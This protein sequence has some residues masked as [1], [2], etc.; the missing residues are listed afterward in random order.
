MCGTPAY[1]APEILLST[2][3]GNSNYNNSTSNNNNNKNNNNNNSTSGNEQRG[4]SKLVDLWSLGAILYIMLSALPPF[5]ENRGLDQLKISQVE[6]TH[7]NW[8]GVSEEAK[9]LVQCLLQAD[10]ANRYDT[11]QTLK[12]PWISV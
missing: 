1:L 10:P 5:D 2:M 11:D 4:Y 8:N 3:I 9:D 6:F 7:K 12:H